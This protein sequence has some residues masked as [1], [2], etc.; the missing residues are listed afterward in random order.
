[1]KNYFR[2]V[3]RGFI[4]ENS[5]VTLEETVR[6]NPKMILIDIDL[7]DMPEIIFAVE[8]GR[9]KNLGI[10]KRAYGK[11][12][13]DD[14]YD[15]E[16][17]VN[18]G[19][20]ALLTPVAH[21]RVT[22]QDVDKEMTIDELFEAGITQFISMI[23]GTL[24]Y[25][26]ITFEPVK[27]DAGI[28][29]QLI[30]EEPMMDEQQMQAKP[31]ELK[32]ATNNNKDE[33]KEKG[34]LE[35]IDSLEADLM[36]NGVNW[37]VDLKGE[38][39][40]DKPGL[41]KRLKLRIENPATGE[42]ERINLPTRRGYE[43]YMFAGDFTRDGSE[44]ILVSFEQPQNQG[45]ISAYM[46]KFNTKSGKPRLIFDSSTFKEEEQGL[47]KFMDRY[48]VQ[49]EPTS[50]SKAYR[51][52][53]SKKP[54]MYLDTL[55][56]KGMRLKKPF[57]GNIGE[58]VAITPIDYDADKVYSLVLVQNITGKDDKDILGLLQTIAKW[59]RGTKQFEPFTQ[60]VSLLGED[61]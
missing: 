55:Y 43:P 59:D 1:M 45:A 14:F 25:G 52:D 54:K 20:Y 30:Q 28:P 5:Q 60:Y 38:R 34:E 29:T 2:N 10:L 50:M 39:S 26:N 21:A 18:T 49:V 58:L 22:E 57:T 19:L 15:Y 61:K 4:P 11:W 31:L 13:L 46:Y 17:A 36:G 23:D 35:V 7:D 53:L 9:K 44:N 24:Y 32:K 56:T 40:K 27:K 48:R 33:D 37:R 6:N 51:I 42:V 47:V 41:I 8:H 12:Y 3:L 16:E